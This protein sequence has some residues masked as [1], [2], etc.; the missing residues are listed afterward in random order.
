MEQIEIQA[1]E[2]LFTTTHQ[3]AAGA[4][5]ALAYCL[6]CVII[7]ANAEIYSQ[8]ATEI[9]PPPKLW[10]SLRYKYV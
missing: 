3:V 2:E 9:S 10:P 4:K 1:I 8:A 5:Y 6:V 7:S